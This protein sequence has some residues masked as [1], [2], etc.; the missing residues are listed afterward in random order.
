MAAS[1]VDRLGKARQEADLVVVAFYRGLWC[2]ICGAWVSLWLSQNAE[3]L[4][5]LKRL[6]ARLLFV[7]SQT[8]EKADAAAKKWG[9]A[10]EDAI[11]AGIVFLG[12]PENAVASEL[13]SEGL[14]SVTV[15]GAPG[16][17]SSHGHTYP[18]GMAQPGCVALKRGA[19]S[20]LYRWE[21]VPKAANMGGATDRPLPGEVW[22]FVKTA[23][24]G[25][26]GGS[27]PKGKTGVYLRKAL[28]A[29]A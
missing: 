21:L 1:A 29:I 6:N 19:Q 25:E 27:M 16:P 17:Y 4:S 7:T 28:C 8:Q 2:P 12:D 18:K 14:L 13:A 3:L 23:Y 15:T 26:A 11:S 22:K 9:M 24:A 20:P 10:D 5:D